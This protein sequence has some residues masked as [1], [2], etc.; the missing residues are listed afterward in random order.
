MF[1]REIFGVIEGYGLVNIVKF[2]RVG[3]YMMY[4]GGGK[5]VKNSKFY[6]VII[7]FYGLE[8]MI[9]FIVFRKKMVVRDN[10]VGCRLWDCVLYRIN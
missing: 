7:L 1:F 3:L 6:L 5:K 4:L 8:R 2:L 10:I 9:V